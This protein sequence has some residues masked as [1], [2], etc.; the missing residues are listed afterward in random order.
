M[1]FFERNFV[2]K[3]ST[4]LM[5]TPTRTLTVAFVRNAQTFGAEPGAKTADKLRINEPGVKQIKAMAPILREKIPHFDIALSSITVS[6]AATA[7][8]L[9]EDDPQAPTVEGTEELYPQSNASI[10]Y[11][12]DELGHAPLSKYEE[13]FEKTPHYTEL[14]TWANA[15]AER[16]HAAIS[17]PPR[18]NPEEVKVLVVSQGVL[19]SAIIIAYVGLLKDLEF[20][21]TTDIDKVCEYAALI[22]QV[23]AGVMAECDCIILSAIITKTDGR[24][25]AS[26]TLK[27][28]ANPLS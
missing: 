21:W 27:F 4:Q 23:D 11:M 9:L 17:R 19:L 15:A 26:V 1:V 3:P 22:T 24:P 20:G 13:T 28:L 25:S 8:R 6:A 5:N 18:G 7:V 10:D 16:I 12:F 14:K 2:T